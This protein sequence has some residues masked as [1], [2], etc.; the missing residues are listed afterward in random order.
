[1]FWAG[2]KQMGAKLEAVEKRHAFKTG[3]YRQHSL[4]LL[5]LSIYV[6]KFTASPTL[7]APSGLQRWQCSGQVGI[8]SQRP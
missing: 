5:G 6:R 2:L 1:M 7:S 3:L 4:D 8:R